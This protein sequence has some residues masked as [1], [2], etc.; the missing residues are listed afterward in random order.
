[1]VRMPNEQLNRV[2][3][4]IRILQG[5]TVAIIIS[6][7]AL[8]KKGSAFKNF[9]NIGPSENLIILGLEVNNFWMYSGIVF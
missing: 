5:W 1:M 6:L 7:L 4:T 3:K 9:Y 2:R 8:L